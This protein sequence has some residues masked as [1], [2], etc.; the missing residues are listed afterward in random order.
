MRR[1][2]QFTTH[3]EHRPSTLQRPAAA[4]NC[5]KRT[6]QTVPRRVDTM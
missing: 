2:Q 1:V 6:K 4:V 5:E 3:R